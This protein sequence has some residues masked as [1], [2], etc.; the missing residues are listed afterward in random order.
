MRWANAA[1]ALLPTPGITTIFPFASPSTASR[2][3]RSA[4]IHMNAGSAASASS[5]VKPA[6]SPKPVSTGPG[7]STV[8]L[9]PVPLSSAERLRVYDS[10]N[11]LPAP[12]PA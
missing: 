7:Q 1:P 8:A 12:Y 2:A 6:A 10:T 5:L 9:T 11:A 4:G 3:T